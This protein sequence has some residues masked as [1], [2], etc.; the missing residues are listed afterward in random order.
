MAL[1]ASV[2]TMRPMIVAA[3]CSL[4]PMFAMAAAD[5]R[6][7]LPV[8]AFG[9]ATWPSMPP[10]ASL[11]KGALGKTL[12]V[13]VAVLAEA[14]RRLETFGRLG[15]TMTAKRLSVV[16]RACSRIPGHEGGRHAGDALYDLADVTVLSLLRFLLD[17]LRLLLGFALT[18]GFFLLFD[19]LLLGLNRA[20]QL[21]KA[22]RAPHVLVGFHIRPAVLA[23]NFHGIP[24]LQTHC[25][26]NHSIA[27]FQKHSL[28]SYDCVIQGIDKYVPPPVY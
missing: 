14:I 10:L 24:N 7:I 8:H 19:A 5:T 4:A 20:A 27:V 21:A 15:R 1:R 13:H 12:S 22:Q 16:V 6:A 23:H 11:V 9:P 18:L 3:M 17:F 25:I 26:S 2:A 28:R